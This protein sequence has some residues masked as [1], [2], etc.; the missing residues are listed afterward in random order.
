MRN[1]S[2]SVHP[3]VHKICHISTIWAFMRG[4]GQVRRPFWAYVRG[5]TLVRGPF[6]AYLRDLR[7]GHRPFWACLRSQNLIWG[8]FWAN[9]RDLRRGQGQFLTY[10]GHFGL[11]EAS[12]AYPEGLM[13]HFEAIKTFS[14]GW[15]LRG[16]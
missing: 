5:P 11:F 7:L 12:E 14:G 4:P 6:W 8:P 2:P 1:V 9:L 3:F 16:H 15:P 13:A 10:F